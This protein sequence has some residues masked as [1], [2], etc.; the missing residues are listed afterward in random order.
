MS[1]V[2]GSLV[3]PGVQKMAM[4]FWDPLDRI[5]IFSHH[6]VQDAQAVMM[7]VCDPN[8][9][10]FEDHLAKAAWEFLA[11]LAL[12]LRYME[13][14]DAC[15]AGMASYLVGPWDDE[16]QMYLH[17]ENC[18]HDG[19]RN[20]VVWEDV[21]GGPSGWIDSEGNPTCSHPM[22]ASTARRMREQDVTERGL[23]L[24][25]AKS[26]LSVYLASRR[27][28]SGWSQVF[29]MQNMRRV[30]FPFDSQEHTKGKSA[31]GREWVSPAI[32][33]AQVSKDI[34]LGEA[35]TAQW[36]HLLGLS[37]SRCKLAAVFAH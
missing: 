7:K 28:T 1:E 3:T 23:V 37:V 31:N 22:I 2:N 32:S 8:G 34:G 36:L 30:P 29:W 13:C 6:D 18:P 16:R 12:H 35:A 15:I 27:H 25:R 21:A 14:A 24:S 4:M 9:E 11:A 20:Y 19:R 5:R 33:L 26:F 10:G 17:M